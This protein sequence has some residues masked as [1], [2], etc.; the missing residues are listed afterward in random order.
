MLTYKHNHIFPITFL[1]VLSEI[2]TR[3][4]KSL[5]GFL[6]NKENIFSG[7]ETKCNKRN[8]ILIQGAL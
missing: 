2:L 8:D 7:T 1:N 5:S 3:S 6:K 4:A